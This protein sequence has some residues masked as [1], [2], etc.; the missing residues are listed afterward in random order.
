MSEDPKTEADPE[1]EADADLETDADADLET[2]ADADQDPDL[3]QDQ[4]PDT[5]D[6]PAA[7]GVVA[8]TGAGGFLGRELARHLL[9]AGCEVRGFDIR[10]DDAAR[11][12]AR[13]AELVTADIRDAAAV[14]DFVA[15]A[16]TVFHCAAVIDTATRAPAAVRQR[17]IDVN[18]GGTRHVVEACLAH[19]VTR[20]IVTSSINAVWSA[21]NAGSDES[22]PLCAPEPGPGHDL[23]SATKSAGEQLAIAADGATTAGGQTLRVVAMRPGGIFGPG[24]PTHLPRI[25]KTVLAGQFAFRVGRRDA[26]SDNVFIDDLVDAHVRAALRLP[27]VGG[28]AYFL[29]DGHPQN[30]FDFFT[31]VALALGKKAPTLTVPTWIMA[32]VVWFAEWIFQLGGPRPFLTRLELAKLNSNQWFSIARAEKDLG[33]VPKVGPEEGMRRCMPTVLRLRDTMPRVHRPHPLWWISIFGGL[34]LLF[35]L[36]FSSAAYAWWVANLTP[37]FPVVVLQWISA[38]A[39]AL[40][41]GEGLYAYLRA[42]GAGLPT[43][44]G[45]GLQTLMLGYPSMRLLL[46]EVRPADPAPA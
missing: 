1:T 40:H 37:M 29:S 25:T 16:D 26:L 27:E 18:V 38:G 30:Y 23:Y 28:R 32:I 19:D 43:A 45:W 10:F 35:T 4:D 3:D 46:R 6:L 15:G 9:A 41:V 5:P 21:E 39:I 11:E 33:W 12:A 44:A 2:D 8:I 34:G 20:L 24:E 13:G 22:V 17:S 42:K 31:P 7:L 36:T 14:A